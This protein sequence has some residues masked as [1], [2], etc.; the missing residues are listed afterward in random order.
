MN[1]KTWTGSAGEYFTFEDMNRVAQNVL[2]LAQGI[3]E[4]PEDL[5]T[6]ETVT[7]SSQFRY[8]EAQ[9]LENVLTL[10]AGTL[11]EEDVFEHHW[12]PGRSVSFV[13][14]NRWEQACS[15]LE[16]SLNATAKQLTWAKVRGRTWK[17]MKALTK[18]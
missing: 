10:V 6:P 18:W 3:G 1:T 7:R 4:N 13:D 11:G 15:R 5:W 9:N 14:F 17:T 16:T 2:S 8:D 12:A